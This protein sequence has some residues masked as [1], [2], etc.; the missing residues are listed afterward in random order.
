MANLIALNLLEE[1][2]VVTVI[3]FFLNEEGKFITYRCIC[4]N[5]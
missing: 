1:T 3:I 2:F 4:L 5:E